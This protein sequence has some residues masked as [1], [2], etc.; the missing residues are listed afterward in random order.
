MTGGER[1]FILFGWRRY[2]EYVTIYFMRKRLDFKELLMKAARSAWFCLLF[3][4]FVPM[5]RKG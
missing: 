1:K 3:A 5:L 2:T 4:A